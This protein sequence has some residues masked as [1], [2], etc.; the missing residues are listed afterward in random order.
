MLEEGYQNQSQAGASPG[1]TT[2]YPQGFER[3]GVAERLEVDVIGPNDNLV[4]AGRAFS[5]GFNDLGLGFKF[6]L[7]Q[8]GRFT[9][10]IDGLFTAA[11]GTAGFTAGG[12]TQT[13][14]LDISYDASPAISFGTTLAGS[15]SAGFTAGGNAARFG[16]FL[17]SAVVTAS[18]PHDVQ[19]YAELV[20]QT[21]LTP[22]GG[23]R[24]FADFGVQ[25]LLGPYVELDVE[26]ADSFTPVAG[27]RFHYLGFGTGIRVK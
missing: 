16:Y 17:P 10:G 9:Y 25:K 22:D 11:T 7:P 15:S 5:S 27:S 12:P 6:E 19:L 14:N 13:V 20:A 2:T 3:F 18:L 4:R 1:V 23:G 8:S 26:Y 24:L 21:K